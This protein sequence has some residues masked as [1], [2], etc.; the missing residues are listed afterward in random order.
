MRIVRACF[1]SVFLSLFFLS[2]GCTKA[3]KKS[4]SIGIDPS[5]FPVN[6]Q[7]REATVL[8]FL[9]ELLQMIGKKC[10][11]NFTRVDMSWDNLTD[12]LQR[13][14]YQ[15]IISPMLPNLIN[16]TKYSFSDP[17]LHTGSVLVVNK[18]SKIKNLMDL[19]GQLVAMSQTNSQLDFLSEYPKVDFTFYEDIRLALELTA[20]GYYEASLIPTIPAHAF[21]KD[22]FHDSLMIVSLPLTS[23]GLRIVTLEK[24][25]EDLLYSIN[26]GLNDLIDSGQYKKLR[27]K[28]DL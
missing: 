23:E 20:K 21:V 24:E 10:G 26:E 27:E 18:Q 7:D 15:A 5:F 2:S 1:V 25:N 22:L 12:G 9:E 11:V 19:S 17:I 8:A 14:R 13:R 16:L 3:F 28:W 6:F 4:Y